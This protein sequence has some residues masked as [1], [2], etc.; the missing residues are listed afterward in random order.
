MF[1]LASPQGR[2]SFDLPSTL[3]VEESRSDVP[4][5]TADP[6]FWFGDGTSFRG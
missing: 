5:A 6:L 4:F 3:S 1:G 2:L